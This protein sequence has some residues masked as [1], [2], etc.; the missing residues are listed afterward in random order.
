V[1]VT[2][3]SG[4]GVTLAAGRITLNYNYIGLSA[5]PS[6]RGDVRYSGSGNRGD[7][8]YVERTSKRNKIGVNSSLTVGAVGNVISNNRGAGI[9]MVGSARNVIQA[10]RIGT[11]P[12]GTKAAGNQ[13]GGIEL[14][15]S[16]K[17]KI[18]GNAVG[19]NDNGPNNPTGTKGSVPENYVA[20]PQGNVISGNKRESI[21]IAAKSKGTL[22]SGNFIGTN[23]A[24]IR[25]IPNSRNGVRV[26]DSDN[27]VF[28]GCTVT[29]EP[30]VYYNVI[31]GNKRNGIQVTDSDN[32]VVQANFFGIGMDNT[33]KVPNR[34]N[35]M[36]FDGNSKNPHV[37]GVIPLGNV[38]AGN[39]QNG[40][41]VTGT[42]SGFETFNTFGGLLAFKG[43]APNKHNGLYINS[44]GGDN[45]AR[46]NVFSGNRR[47]GI[48]I[49]GNTTGMTV[50]PNIIGLDTNGK[51]PLRNGGN[52][53]VLTGNA[54]K[55]TIGG[56]RVSVI[57]QNAFS[58]NV[59][60]G[61]VLEGNAR[62]NKVYNT[63]IGTGVDIST[64]VPNL[65]GGI[66]V[67]GKA[68]NNYI[69]ATGSQKI[70]VIAGNI[71]YGVTL[72]KNSSGNVVANN[73]I[74][75]GREGFSVP[76]T[77]GPVL[78]QGKKNVVKNNNTN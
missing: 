18:G 70:N 67:R 35:G 28:R 8:V 39:G 17:N 10:N 52:G 54:R 71:G 50:D 64:P 29:D 30:F 41:A 16:K 3:A 33:T 4:N 13:H 53:V 56:N 68:R 40:I 75:K 72:K 24:G 32:T 76:N 36:L 5:V 21:L 20:P 57:P 37:G 65:K 6:S 77:K 78:N 27:T 61:L 46:T 12:A 58:G 26:L 63:F 14:F 34:R 55:N 45:L 60:Y 48:L 2:E 62:N 43:A 59:G 7:G 51:G 22:L 1:S 38:A 73:N 23:A 74:G 69:G 66:I 11:N 42:V 9:R 49:A 31:S 47:N 25:A 19:S 44:T 15:G